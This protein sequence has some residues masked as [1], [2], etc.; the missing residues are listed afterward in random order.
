M[1]AERERQGIGIVLVGN[2]SSQVILS[3]GGLTIGNKARWLGKATF[4]T[5]TDCCL[6]K[7]GLVSAT[8]G[9][10]ERGDGARQC[11]QLVSC[12]PHLCLFPNLDL[13]HQLPFA[14]VGLRYSDREIMLGCSIDAG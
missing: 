5:G 6:M 4:R 7:H 2:S 11:V 3:F 9:R 10:L 14:S 8:S 12:L 1:A 13:V